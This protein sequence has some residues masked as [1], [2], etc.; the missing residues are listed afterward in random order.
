MYEN[1]WKN[2]F[3]IERSQWE[4]IYRCGISLIHEKVIAEFNYKLL[5]DLLNSNLSVSKWNKQMS[6]KCEIC[7]CDDDIKHLLFECTL[8]EN[9]WRIV[10][11][12]LKFDIKWKTLVIVFDK[13][14]KNTT[15]KLKQFFSLH[16]L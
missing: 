4:N 1:K 2:A 8:V 15:I 6:P 14:I 3:K 10:S 13:E 5:N 9:I 16:L 7:N 11:H 12:F